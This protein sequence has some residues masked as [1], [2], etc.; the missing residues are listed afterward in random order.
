MG[1]LS[2]IQATEGKVKITHDR[3]EALTP[4]CHLIALA[5]K[6]PIATIEISDTGR[7]S[8]GSPATGR[9]PVPA[10]GPNY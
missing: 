7:G 10:N 6:I 1:D 5:L 8:A 2:E 4:V 9:K 3:Y